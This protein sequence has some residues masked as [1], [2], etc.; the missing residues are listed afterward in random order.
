MAELCLSRAL[1]YAEIWDAHVFKVAELKRSR[2]LGGLW[3]G[4]AAWATYEDKDGAGAHKS[5][6]WERGDSRHKARS[7][8]TALGKPRTGWEGERS[9]RCESAVPHTHL[10]PMEAAAA[11][12][13]WVWEVT[14]LPGRLSAGTGISALSARVRGKRTEKSRAKAGGC[15]KGLMR[16]FPYG[17]GERKKNQNKATL[18]LVGMAGVGLTATRWLQSHLPPCSAPTPGLKRVL[19]SQQVLADSRPP[20]V[21]LA[22][23]T[24]ELLRVRGCARL[25]MAPTEP[26][27]PRGRTRGSNQTLGCDPIQLP[28]PCARKNRPLAVPQPLRLHRGGCHRPTAAAP[29]RG[30]GCRKVPAPLFAHRRQPLSRLFALRL[31]LYSKC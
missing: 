16:R 12:A 5:T 14:E 9:R 13:V 21:G 31:H 23:T 6:V 15:A 29:L 20:C 19:S 22:P 8:S 30:W 27:S 7:T 11:A 18:P 4:R 26:P 24:P 3:C 28:A 25:G 1:G 2:G 17:E 10:A